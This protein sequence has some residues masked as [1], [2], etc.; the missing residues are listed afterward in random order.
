ML[1]WLYMEIPV[2]RLS[3][4]LQDGLLKRGWFSPSPHD[5]P[6]HLMGFSLLFAT[7]LYSRLLVGIYLW[8]PDFQ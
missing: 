8:L 5:F 4:S 7:I 1:K 6:P 2:A 3:A